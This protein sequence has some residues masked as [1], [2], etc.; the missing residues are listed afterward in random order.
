LNP[1]SAQRR[2]TGSALQ[3]SACWQRI[4]GVEWRLL[5]G[6][7]EEEVRELLKLARRRRLRRGEVVFHREDPADSMHLVGKGRF[8]VRVTTPLGEPATIAIRG[9]GD[10]FGEMALVGRE[11]KRS[12]TVEALEEAETFCVYEHDFH[13]LR[14]QHPAVNELVTRFLVSEVRMLNE[15]LLEALYVPVERRVLRRLNELASLYG[16]G[17]E[18][19]ADIPL[20]QEELAGLAGASRATVNGVLREAKRKGLLELGRGKTRILDREELARRAR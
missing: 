2:I 12:A 20:T 3:A 5:Q 6:V 15:R 7:S 1:R 8:A 13:Q 19:Q 17:D 18:A 4:P 16:R 10:S 11:A 14:R 9:P